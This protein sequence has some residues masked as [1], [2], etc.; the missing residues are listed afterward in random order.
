MANLPSG[1]ICIE[2]SKLA[3]G[4]VSLR[5]PSLFVSEQILGLDSSV[6]PDQGERNLLFLQQLEKIWAGDVEDVGGLDI[7]KLAGLTHQNWRN[8]ARGRP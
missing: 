8:S 2:F 1:Q 5:I 6:S 3:E 4:S 7:E